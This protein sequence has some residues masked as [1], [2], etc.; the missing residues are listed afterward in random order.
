MKLVQDAIDNNWNDRIWYHYTQLVDWDAV[1]PQCTDCAQ[2]AIVIEKLQ[3]KVNQ[4][5]K[6]AKDLTEKYIDKVEE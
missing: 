6:N 3:A 5:S 2:W 1:R 4:L